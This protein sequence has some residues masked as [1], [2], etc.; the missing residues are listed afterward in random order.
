MC[1]KKNYE[2]FYGFHSN[3]SLSE[4]ITLL[5]PY[6]TCDQNLIQLI[7][8]NALINMSDKEKEKK[9]SSETIANIITELVNHQSNE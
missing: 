9:I 4:L 2:D 6:I 5:G 1:N 8:K 3:Y 7:L